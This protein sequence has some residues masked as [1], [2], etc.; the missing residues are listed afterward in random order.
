MGNISNDEN[1]GI[2]VILLLRRF[3]CIVFINNPGSKVWKKKLKL[4]ECMKLLII[5]YIALLHF[6][7]VALKFCDHFNF[8]FFFGQNYISQLL[9]FNFSILV[10]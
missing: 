2:M 10:S 7:S 1:D 3:R 9:I 4:C 5:K 8:T 6:N